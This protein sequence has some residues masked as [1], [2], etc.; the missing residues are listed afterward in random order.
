MKRISIVKI[1]QVKDGSIPYETKAVS[2]PQVV[3][4]LLKKYLA[5]AD[6]EHFGVICLNSKN[7]INNITTCSIGTI[8]ECPVYSREIF[9]TA[10]LSNSASIILFHNH[11]SGH[12]APS[13]S[14][15]KITKRIQD[16]GELL[17]VKIHDHIVIGETG[18]VSFQEEGLL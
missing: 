2:S 3:V 6:R 14:D 7:E 15:R 4:G 9:K 11:P 10:I 5:G 18:Y 17:G 16:G 1:Q 8:D 13:H 12:P